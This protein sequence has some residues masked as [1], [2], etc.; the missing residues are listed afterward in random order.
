MLNSNYEKE[1]E[2]ISKRNSMVAS[3]NG[4]SKHKIMSLLWGRRR[5]Q[6]DTNSYREWKYILMSDLIEK[7]HNRSNKQ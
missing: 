1:D 7:L 3:K 6:T 5:S 4:V 2:C